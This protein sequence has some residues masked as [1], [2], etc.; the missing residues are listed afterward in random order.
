MFNRL[1]HHTTN[2]HCSHDKWHTD[3]LAQIIDGAAQAIVRKGD[4]ENGLG[5]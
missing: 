2:R 4:T 3:M 5:I 1:C